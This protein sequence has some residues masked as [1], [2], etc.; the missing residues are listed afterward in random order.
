MIWIRTTSRLTIPLQFASIAFSLLWLGA[1]AGADVLPIYDLEI[2]TFTEVED[3]FPRDYSDPETA[4]SELEEFPRSAMSSVVFGSPTI[5]STD[6]GTG[7]H[8]DAVEAGRFYEQVKLD[9]GLAAEG[10]TV[11]A[12]GLA[13]DGYELHDNGIFVEPMDFI[14][15]DAIA[16]YSIEVDFIVNRLSFLGSNKN[17]SVFYDGL[18]TLNR[19]DFTPDG[20]VLIYSGDSTPIPLGRYPV[21]ERINLRAD[22]DLETPSLYLTL[23]DREI[24]S[25]E[26]EALAPDLRSIRLSLAVGNAFPMPSVTVHDVYV[27][28][29]SSLE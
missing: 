27:E 7:L 20:R 5:V 23:N 10:A 1:G 16:G 25:T 13:A 14:S 28:S 2:D 21:G 8:L 6:R 15:V 22:F 17:F 29:L 4:P 12:C 9:L 3:L 19:V 18:C 11:A 24:F 26:D